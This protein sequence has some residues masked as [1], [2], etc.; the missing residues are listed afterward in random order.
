[1]ISDTNIPIEPK[2]AEEYVTGYLIATKNGYPCGMYKN[3]KLAEEI[4]KEIDGSLFYLGLV[5]DDSIKLI[6]LG[7]YEGYKFIRR[8]DNGQ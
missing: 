5:Q 8:D 6:Y 1:M 3:K 2:R 7:R 4:A